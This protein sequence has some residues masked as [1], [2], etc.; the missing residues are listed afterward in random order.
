M[1]PPT[2]LVSNE[3][4]WKRLV[5]LPELLD[6]E[7][8]E[9]EVPCELV[10]EFRLSWLEV[11]LLLGEVLDPDEDEL[12]LSDSLLE[13]AL[14]PLDGWFEEL[15]ELLGVLGVELVEVPEVLEE[16]PS[17][18]LAFAEPETL[19]DAL[20]E[21]E[22]EPL[23]SLCAVLLCADELLR[24]GCDGSLCSDPEADVLEDPCALVSEVLPETLVLL[25]ERSTSVE[26]LIEVLL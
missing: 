14:L 8:L 7:T 5:S 19:P 11:P 4:P 1:A 6:P 24:F 22:M 25:L 26:L 13:V 3:P 18:P 21:A 17:D 23:W 20:P 12:E 10:L 15:F 16:V 9:P 2:L